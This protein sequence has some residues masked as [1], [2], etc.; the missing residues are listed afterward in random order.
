MRQSLIE[1]NRQLLEQSVNLLDQLPDSAY[2]AKSPEGSQAPPL[3]PHFR[4]CLD[5]YVCFLD[6]LELR[7]IDYG[8]RSRRRDV[9]TFR[10]VAMVAL[11]AV[12]ER[13]GNIEVATLAEPVELRREASDEGETDEW[14]SS[15]VGR[16]LQFLLSH[17][18]HHYA[19]IA[20]ALRL[21]GHTVPESF[22]V[23]PSTL[24]HWRHE[25]RVT[26]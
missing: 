23:A 9:E 10:E 14:F 15:S 24:D 26:S 17:T 18:V 16:E 22:G 5:F 3:G 8:S 13:V 2:S 21:E 6:G 4:H 20:L 11:G 7:V 19:L 12:A 1:Q 25:G